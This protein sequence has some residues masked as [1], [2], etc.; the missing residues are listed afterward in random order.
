MEENI[1]INRVYRDIMILTDDVNLKALSN[2]FIDILKYICDNYKVTH[3]GY[4]GMLIVIKNYNKLPEKLKMKVRELYIINN[5]VRDYIKITTQPIYG[6]RY[7]KNA[8]LYYIGRYD[9]CKVVLDLEV[10]IVRFF[11]ALDTC[12]GGFDCASKLIK[13]KYN[14]NCESIGIFNLIMSDV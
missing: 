6:R 7:N 2:K 5:D 10:N 8:L 1:Y 3:D 9:N 12:D 13:K 11:R 14:V 4:V